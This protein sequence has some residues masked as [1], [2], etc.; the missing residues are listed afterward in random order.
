M[1]RFLVSAAL[2][3]VLAS[4]ALPA[5]TAGEG[6]PSTGKV[7]LA[8]PS[9]QAAVGTDFVQLLVFDI[10]PAERA[11]ICLDKITARKR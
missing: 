3:T 2:A 11:S 8:F 7:T 5:C 4:I 10:T 9:T 1:K 6:D